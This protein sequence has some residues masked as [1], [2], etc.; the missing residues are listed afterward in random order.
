MMVIWDALLHRGLVAALSIEVPSSILVGHLVH[1]EK[2]F[3]P[4]L[5]FQIT[6]GNLSS[7]AQSLPL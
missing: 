3:K 6:W 5:I 1:L 2:E 4:S 7:G